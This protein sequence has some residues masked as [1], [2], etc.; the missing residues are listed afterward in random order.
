[1]KKLILVATF[2][3]VSIVAFSQSP[4]SS[5]SNQLNVGVG[6]S[7]WGVP[8]YIGLD[9]GIGKDLTIGAELSYR[10]Y[11]ENWNNDKYDHSIMGFSGNLNYHLNTLLSIPHQWDVYVGPNIGFYVWNSPDTYGGDHNS[12]LGLGAQL[13][14]RYFLSDKIAL[15]LELGGGNAFSGGKFGLTFKL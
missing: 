3:L 2:A 11:N 6:L 5:G 9:H 1:M 13:G 8:V 15:N 7:G 14:F 12:G 4:L 10:S